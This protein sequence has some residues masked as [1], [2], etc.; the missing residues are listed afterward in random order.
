[1]KEVIVRL[2]SEP[3]G[4]EELMVTAVR[5][6]VL[7]GNDVTVTREINNRRTVPRVSSRRVSLGPT[8]EY[9]PIWS[10]CVPLVSLDREPDL[11]F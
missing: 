7:H 5:L 9:L 2:V 1:L 6:E 10:D 3:E 11:Q 4:R 8:I